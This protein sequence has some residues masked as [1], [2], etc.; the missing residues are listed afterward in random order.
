MVR[1]VFGGV[2]DPISQ[3][4]EVQQMEGAAGAV[5]VLTG[6]SVLGKARLLDALRH[7][8]SVSSCFHNLSP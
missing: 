3:K 6:M 5:P 8:D 2:Y 4:A 7:L 1:M